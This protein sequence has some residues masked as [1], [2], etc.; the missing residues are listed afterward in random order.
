MRSNRPRIMI[1]DDHAF[2]ADACKK[3]LEP[4]FDVVA[5]VGDGRG[6]AMLAAILAGGSPARGTCPVA[7]VATS[8][9]GTGDQFTGSPE[10]KAPVGRAE[11]LGRIRQGG[12]QLDR[13]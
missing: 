12:K 10:V 6:A 3:L 8:G 11:M 13:S 7:T 1:A 4:E 2:L 9:G 5:T